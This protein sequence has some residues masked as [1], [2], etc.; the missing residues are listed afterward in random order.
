MN[1]LSGTS[2][3]EV[4]GQ[5]MSNIMTNDMRLSSITYGIILLLYVERGQSVKKMLNIL[6]LRRSKHNK[7]VYRYE[8]E[9]GRI[10]IIE[11][12]EE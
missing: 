11:K 10:N 7:E 12:Y 9:K 1:Y 3:G 5:L 8:I 2:F 6:K 4:K